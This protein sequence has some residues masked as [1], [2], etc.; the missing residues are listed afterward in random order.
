LSSLQTALAEMPPESA[1]AFIPVDCP[2]VAEETVARLAETFAHR[3]AATQFVIPRLGN[4]RGHPV[5]AAPLIA[6]EMLAL[7]PTEEARTIVHRHVPNTQYV[8]VTDPGIFADIDTPE[9]YQR[10]LV[11][12]RR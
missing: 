5:F 11:E 7:A 8:D 9:A 10:L 12:T 3:D 1:F 4:K 2:A 6:R